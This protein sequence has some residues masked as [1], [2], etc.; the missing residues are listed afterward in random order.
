M[1]LMSCCYALMPL[2][3]RRFHLFI[4][5]MPAMLSLSI[6]QSPDAMLL[7]IFRGITPLRFHFHALL[8]SAPLIFAAATLMLMPL[9]C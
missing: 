6:F 5:T 3:F 2:Y 7:L 9:R 1:L 4:A 8:S